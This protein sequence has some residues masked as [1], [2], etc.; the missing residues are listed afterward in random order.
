MNDADDLQLAHQLADVATRVARQ[1]FG[2]RPE[3][4]LKSD[5]TPVTEADLAVERALL[6]LLQAQRPTDH[7]LSEEAGGHLISSGLLDR[8]P[9]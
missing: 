5:S 9:H 1:Y 3:Y 6:D 8:R 2:G 7:V 4:H